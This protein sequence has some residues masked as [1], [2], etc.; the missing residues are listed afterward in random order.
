MLGREVGI[1][2]AA[3]AWITSRDTGESSKAI[4]SHMTGA[5]C[6]GHLST[7]SEPSDLGRCLRLLESVPEWSPRMPEMACHGID[8]A[9]MASRWDEL[10]AYMIGEVGIHWE[11][12]GKAPKTY[13]LMQSILYPEESGN[14]PR[15]RIILPEPMP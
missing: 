9:R 7:P 5:K 11:K 4:W 15:I 1:P 6:S 2:K 13:A 3:L 14:H 12:G 8:W 10:A